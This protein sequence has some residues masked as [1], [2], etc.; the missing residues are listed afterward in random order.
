MNEQE[1]M[2]HD[3]ASRDTYTNTS[4]P[5]ATQQEQDFDGC[6]YT[7]PDG[8]HGFVYNDKPASERSQQNNGARI[9]MVVILTTVLAVC[10]AF[11][12]DW[13]AAKNL[14]PYNYDTIEGSGG[15]VGP[16]GGLYIE[17]DTA[18]DTEENVV[19]TLQI[20]APENTVT[21]QI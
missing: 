18:S 3:S 10:G 14:I 12:G 5:S 1:Q 13:M 16:S 17:S 7:N 21:G 20:A 9:A 8:S 15:E 19:E 11:V 4:Q 6:Q 2:N